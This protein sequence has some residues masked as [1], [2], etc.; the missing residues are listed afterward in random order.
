MPHGME[1]SQRA[2]APLLAVWLLQLA[3][4]FT[5]SATWSPMSRF[6]LTHAVASGEGFALGAWADA[7]GDRARVGD[8]WFSDK[9]PLP[10][11]MGVVPYTL[12]RS[13]H[14]L[15]GRVP[16]DFE[17]ESRG[18]VPAT[19][20]LLNTSAQQLLYATA[21]GVSGVAFVVLALHLHTMLSRRHD[22]RTALV[23]TTLVCLGTPLF[24]YATSL[25]GHV[26][27]AAFLTVALASLDPLG[28][29][30]RL[31]LTGF[32]VAGAAGCEYITAIPGALIGVYALLSGGA[33]EIPRRFVVL[34]LGA[35]P[36]VVLVGGY[37]HVC[38]GAPWR[39]GYSH[40]TNPLF[41]AGHQRGVMGIGPPSIDALVGLLFGTRRGLFYVAPIALLAAGG[42]VLA[43]A[44]SA[45]EG[46]AAGAPVEVREAPVPRIVRWLGPDPL[47]ALGALLGLVLLLANAGYYMWW[48]GAAAGPRHLVPALPVLGFGLAR[49]WEHTSV[50]P[51]VLGAGAVSVFSMLAFASVG[52]EAPEQGNVLTTFVL[53]RLLAGEISALPSAT[54]LGLLLGLPPLL[55]ILPWIGWFLL[56]GRALWLRTAPSGA[57]REQ[58]P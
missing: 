50:R 29:P 11:L 46:G 5:P 12:I 51:F 21:V 56:L 37:H 42:L 26:P 52:I 54:N 25:Y 35:L 40:L 10:A 53:P 30:P 36:V 8:A 17:A 22:A 43:P 19:R 34:A 31:A 18:D 47:V 24:P 23:G 14:V 55:S 38:F 45:R 7:T 15:V 44:R 41:V 27:A 3:A 58:S 16:P 28:P 48:G 6:A 2:V 32:C 49:L 1:P 33:R 13:I 20:V 39:T 57:T 9:A 4:F